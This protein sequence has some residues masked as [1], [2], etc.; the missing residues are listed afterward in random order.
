MEWTREKTLLLISEYRQRRGL[1]DMTCDE[2][3]KKDVKQRLLNEVS[4]VLGGNIPISELEKKFHT[5]RTQYHREINRMKRKEP[6]NSK[7]FGFKNLVFLSSPFAC[8]STKGRSK[9]DPSAHK[10]ILGEVNTSAAAAAGSAEGNNMNDEYMIASRK[11][12]ASSRAQELE[13]LIEETT[14]DV[15]DIDDD[16]PGVEEDV[17]TKPKLSKELSGTYVHINEDEQEPLETHTHH[18]PQQQPQHTHQS[19]M[20]E[21][22]HSGNAVEAVSFQASESG[23]LHYQTTTTSGYSGNSSSVHVVP[24]RIIKIQRRDT[25]NQE[26]GYFEE[27]ST[28]HQLHPPPPKRLYFDPNGTHST[29]IL[30]A[31]TLAAATQNGNGS[32]VLTT[33][34]GTAVA[35]GTLRLPRVNAIVNTQSLSPPKP[36]SSPIPPPAVVSSQRDEFST[37]G[38]YVANEMRAI[39]NREVL[40]ALKHKINTAIFEA[41]MAELQK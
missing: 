2:Y 25:S 30:S 18:Q 1:W 35:G 10:Y 21:L 22:H 31:S 39:G 26:N 20:M 8:R 32:N 12:H 16:E 19:S 41:N 6:Y 15:E 33:T 37:Y 38:E 7:W 13:K 24:T 14:K 28:Q 11:S 23:E 5:L 40:I 4:D 34:A 9:E 27:Q 17:D 3:R 29:T 36:A